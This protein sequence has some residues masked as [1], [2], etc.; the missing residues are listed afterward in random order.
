MAERPTRQFPS[1][2]LASDKTTLA[3][4]NTKQVKMVLVCED[5][6]ADLLRG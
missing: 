2:K 5:F 3:Q 1:G 4:Q 6:D